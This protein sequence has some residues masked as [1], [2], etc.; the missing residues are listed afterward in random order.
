MAIT[1]QANRKIRVAHEF[2]S[3]P[4]VAK[5]EFETAWP[6]VISTSGSNEAGSIL[7]EPADG[8]NNEGYVGVALIPT[9]VKGG[10]AAVKDTVLAGFDGVLPGKEVFLDRSTG[11]FTQLLAVEAAGPDTA[12][13]PT[14]AVS[15]ALAAGTYKVSA[16]FVDSHGGVSLATAPVSITIAASKKIH[17][18]DFEQP[19]PTGVSAIRWYLSVAAGS[20][21]LK[22]IAQNA[23]TA[24]DINSLPA[25]DAAVPATTAAER[26]SRRVG[27]GATPY[28]IV[29]D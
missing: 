11:W 14:E 6:A 7:M 1:I 19:L 4:G 24:F 5:V 26:G 27:V 12:P 18:A 3:K 25:S 15:G 13:V 29:L 16:A 20:N 2:T 8:D 21:T 28:L 23:G 22:Q 9:D 10:I 17:L